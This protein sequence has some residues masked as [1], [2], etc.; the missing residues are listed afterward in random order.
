VLVDGLPVHAGKL[1]SASP[2]QLPLAPADARLGSA[3]NSL[4][5]TNAEGLQISPGRHRLEL[6]YT[7]LSFSAPERVR[8]RYRLEN[9]DADWVEAGPL[10]TAIYSYVPPGKYRFQVIACNSDGVWNEE[11]TS[12]SLQ[13][14]PYFWQNRWFIGLAALGLLAT[15]GGASRLVEQRK[16]QRRLSR[17]E[18]ERALERERARIAQDLHDDL[19]SSLTRISL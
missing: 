1:V 19:G 3:T 15:V 13:V 12:L 18:Q 16:H 7:G 4:T 14:L 8:F 2:H 17:I 5:S 11:G 6:R 9:L 10:R